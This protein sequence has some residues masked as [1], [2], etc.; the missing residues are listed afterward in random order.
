VNLRK[1]VYFS[2]NVGI[3]AYYACVQSYRVARYTAARLAYNGIMR[4]APRRMMPRRLLR[5]LYDDS[6][7][8]LLAIIATVPSLEAGRLMQRGMSPQEVKDELDARYFYP[9]IVA[10]SNSSADAEELDRNFSTI[11]RAREAVFSSIDEDA[12][13]PLS[14][15]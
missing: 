12:G 6:Q 14:P 7:F 9:R 1:Y 3:V 4:H 11:I 8:Q 2:W 15:A 10:A 13:G 5:F